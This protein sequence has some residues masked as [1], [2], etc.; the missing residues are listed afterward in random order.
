[1][2]DFFFVQYFERIWY[3]INAELN[4]KLLA[5]FI[6]NHLIKLSVVNLSELLNDNTWVFPTY[7]LT[8]LLNRLLLCIQS[9]TIQKTFSIGFK[10][11]E[12][13]GSVTAT[14]PSF[15][16]TLPTLLVQ[17]IAALSSITTSLDL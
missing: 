11:G 2:L 14:N 15:Q 12:Y 6:F 13:W 9:F 10:F 16:Q 3:L 17:W 1:M 5:Q 7:K 8:Y 4:L